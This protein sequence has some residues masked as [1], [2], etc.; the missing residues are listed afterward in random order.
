[1]QISRS[2]STAPK[3][4]ALATVVSELQGPCVGCTNCVGL[5]EALIDTLVLPDLILSRKRSNT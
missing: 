3:V 2:K 5:C 4:K 1:M